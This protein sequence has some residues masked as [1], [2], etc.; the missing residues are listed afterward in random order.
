MFIRPAF[1]TKMVCALGLALAVFGGVAGSALSGE[2]GGALW[3]DSEG[4]TADSANRDAAAIRRSQNH[5]DRR[6]NAI[7]EHVGE[8]IAPPA[9]EQ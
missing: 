2:L 6:F 9:T 8:D 4:I 5:E 1:K 3:N 7:N